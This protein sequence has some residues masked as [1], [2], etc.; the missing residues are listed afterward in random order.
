MSKTNEGAVKSTA[1]KA[2][3]A[4]EVTGKVAAGTV[5]KETMENASDGL[6]ALLINSIKSMYWAENHLVKTLPKMENAAASAELQ[7]GIA[8]HLKQTEIQVQ[9]LEQVFQMLGIKVQAQ[10]CDGMEGITKEGES[11]VEMTDTGTPARD[12]GVI[13]ASQKVE[14]FEMAAYSGI[15]QLATKLGYNDIASLLQESLAEEQQ[16][17]QQLTELAETIA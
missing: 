3:A 14:H 8:K 10:K 13:M 1:K 2:V 11:V 9:R 6:Q 5:T 7:N 15:I 16:T 17:S 12:T 4:S